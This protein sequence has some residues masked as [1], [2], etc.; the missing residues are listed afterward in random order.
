MT[1]ALLIVAGLY[2]SL[3]AVFGVL[4]VWRGIAKVDAQAQGAGLGFRL[5]VLP[6]SVAL[7]P[8]LFKLWAAR[9]GAE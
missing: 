1:Q 2:L 7:W 9:R 6:G 8:I 4:F 3:G 5:L